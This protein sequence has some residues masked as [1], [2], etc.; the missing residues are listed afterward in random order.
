M[1]HR[2]PH[3][4]TCC[5]NESGPAIIAM[6]DRAREITVQTFMRRCDWR[7]WA[8]AMGYHRSWL[9]LSGDYHVAYYRSVWR[10]KPCYY[11]VHSAIEHIFQ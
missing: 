6:V 7:P 5:V 8:E 1:P 9:T 3:Y 4:R 10:G 2:K 11:V